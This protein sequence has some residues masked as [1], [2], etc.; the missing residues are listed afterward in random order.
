M[1]KHHSLFRSTWD[2][3]S[4]RFQ[5]FDGL[6]DS[7]VVFVLVVGLPS[8]PQYDVMK[9]QC[10]GCPGMITF[11]IKGKLEHATTFLCSLKVIYGKL[12]FSSLNIFL[13]LFLILFDFWVILWQR[14]QIFQPCISYIF[15]L[16]TS[17][18]VCHI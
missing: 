17:S 18:S 16:K 9:R 5:R 11:Y 10:T 7:C 13:R 12:F 15:Q 14:C 2:E 3:Q 6:G 8:H 1:L 4:V